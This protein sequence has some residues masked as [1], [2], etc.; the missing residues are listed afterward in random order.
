M[1]VY[2]SSQGQSLNSIQGVAVQQQQLPPKNSLGFFLFNASENDQW[3]RDLM[4]RLD[5][6]RDACG[7]LC[8]INDKESYEFHTVKEEEKKKTSTTDISG[9]DP[10][11]QLKVPNVNCKA[12]IGSADIDAGDL[13]FPST[14]PEELIPFYTIGGMMM[15]GPK[16][17]YKQ[18]YLGGEAFTTLWTK[19]DLDLQKQQAMEEPTTLY[20]TYGFAI[21]QSVR[22]KLLK[23]N[24]TDKSVLVIG[25]ELPWVEAICLGVGAG[26]VTTLEYGSINSTH[27]QVKTLT[28]AEFR[29]RYLA[30]TL[31]LFD[32][33]VTHSSLEHSGLGRYGDALNPWGDILAVA[34]AWCVT[35]PNGALITMALAR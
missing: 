10:L 35:K 32:V 14:L 30:G 2:G 12:I 7:D 17:H 16:A 19:E 29:K 24:L 25:S 20:G 4:A 1:Y 18:G 8:T 11:P 26:L 22:D 5:R 9:L 34:R 28:P 31:G 6:I 23:L 27:P 15:Y 21:T 3:K 13:S 33:I